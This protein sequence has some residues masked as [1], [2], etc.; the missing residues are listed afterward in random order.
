MMVKIAYQRSLYHFNGFGFVYVLGH[1][2]EILLEPYH[3]WVTN[4]KSVLPLLSALKWNQIH[5]S[6]FERARFYS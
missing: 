2:Q 3:S 4:L 6:N 5:R 1:R